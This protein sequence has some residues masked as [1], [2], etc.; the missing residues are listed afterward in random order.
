MPRPLQEDVE[1]YEHSVDRHLQSDHFRPS[2]RRTF[3]E[4]RQVG[5][6]NPVVRYERSSLDL[7]RPFVPLNLLVADRPLFRE[8][9]GRRL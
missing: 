2:L 3:T 4:I 6:V 7:G 5:L 9:A 8:S 1:Y